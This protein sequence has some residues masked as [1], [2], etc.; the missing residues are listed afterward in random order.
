MLNKRGQGMSINAVIIIVLGIIVLAVIILGFSLG[1]DKFVPFLSPSNNVDEIR[2]NCEFACRQNQQ[3]AFCSQ[4]RDL[5]T[6]SG[7]YEGSC[8]AFVTGIGVKKEGEE[9]PIEGAELTN[10]KNLKVS[11]NKCERVECPSS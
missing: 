6:E 10:Y 11:I 8:N 7:T 9:N 4:P 5:I 2:E 3:Y 1:W